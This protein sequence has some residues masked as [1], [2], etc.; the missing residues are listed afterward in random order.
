MDKWTKN[1]ANG[2]EESS[3]YKF[4]L[5]IFWNPKFIPRKDQEQTMES[6]RHSLREKNLSE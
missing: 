5:F 1:K 6:W 2:V 4:Y 3:K